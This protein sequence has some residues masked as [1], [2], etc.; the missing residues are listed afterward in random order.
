MMM[1]LVPVGEYEMGSSRAEIDAALSLCRQTFSDCQDWWFE[2]ESLRT[3]TIRQPFWIDETEVTRAL[4]QQCVNVGA[5]QTTPNP[6]YSTRDNQPITRIT[7]SQAQ[8]FCGWRDARLPTDIEWE[9]VARGP[10][11][12]IFPWGN[13]FDGSRTN[14]C[15]SGCPEVWADRG[16]N[17]GFGYEP[18]PVGNYQAGQSWVGT[19]DMVGNVYEWVNV[20][21]GEG[22]RGGSYVINP[23]F[24]RTA[25][26]ARF[27][28]ASE[29]DD[30]GFRCVRDFQE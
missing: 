28:D 12:L 1:M 29:G 11:H 5:C 25:V 7:W 4:Y 16:V 6:G 8:N 24:V 17:D 10:D 23:G 9:Y 26:R 20:G 19:L 22:L 14:Y 30:W 18:A 27:N 21:G 15:D 3:Q 2:D 13:S